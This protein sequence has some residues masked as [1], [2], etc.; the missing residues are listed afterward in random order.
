MPSLPGS[1]SPKVLL[2]DMMSGANDYGRELALSLAGYSELTVVTV[3][4]S[5]LM[6]DDKLRVLSIFPAFG[7]EGGSGWRKGLNTAIAYLKLIRELIRHRSAV[8]HVQFFR[9]DWIDMLLYAMLRPLLASLIYT[10][11][12]AL[13]HEPKWWHRAAYRRWYRL[14]DR[15]HVLSH[16]AKQR[17]I[18]HAGLFPEQV[19]VVPHGN[20]ARIER[21]T[22]ASPPASREALGIPAN[23]QIGLIFG[24]M[25]D[26]KGVDLLISAA[27]ILPES[28]PVTFLVAGGGDAAL[29]E[30]YRAEVAIRGLGY[31]FKFI[32]RFLPD[33]ELAGLLRTSDFVLFPYRHI[34]QSGA[35]MLALTFG[36]AILASDIAGFREYVDHEKTAI[37]CDTNN[38]LAFSSALKRLVDDP[39]LRN[40]LRIGAKNASIERYGWDVIAKRLIAI[41]RGG[42][43]E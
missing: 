26:Y 1:D 9:F 7:A 4:N 27:A 14:V 12:N 32:A 17:V 30:K 28:L 21:Q 35:L 24:L 6:S 11:H 29:M 41:Y 22:S 43:L 40:H 15:V 31:R 19:V 42:P 10:A 3:T 2:V 16:Y 39:E 33:E 8:V 36:C 37:L 13:P 34:Y 5:P 20:Y 23:H 38:A 18:E 25:R